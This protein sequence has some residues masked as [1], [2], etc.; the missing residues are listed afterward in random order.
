[1]QQKLCGMRVIRHSRRELAQNPLIFHFFQILSTLISDVQ[2]Q[3][4]TNI[5]TSFF[6]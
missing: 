1:M 3:D 5:V 4:Y 2:T 6:E